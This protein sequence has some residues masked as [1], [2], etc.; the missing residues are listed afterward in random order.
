M[1]AGLALEFGLIVNAF[2]EV[3][4]VICTL[5]IGVFAVFKKNLTND[6]KVEVNTFVEAVGCRTEGLRGSMIHLTLKCKR[7]WAW[8]LE[9]GL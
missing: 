9:S 1:M 8:H 2:F 6:Y 3:W 7:C 5:A 4:T